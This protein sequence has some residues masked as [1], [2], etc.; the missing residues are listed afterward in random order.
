MKKIKLKKGDEVLVLAG[1]DKGRK[2]R[3]LETQPDKNKAIVEGINVAKKAQK[4]NPQ[5]NIQGGLIDK[6]L[7][8]HLSNLM[9]IDATTGKPGRAGY[10]VDKNTGTKIRI[11][12]PSKQKVTR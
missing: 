4:P 3:I 12:K 1:K 5:K 9:L 11:T 6:S 7:P 2:G 8:I 10:Q